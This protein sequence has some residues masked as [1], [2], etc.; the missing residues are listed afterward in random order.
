M[1]AEMRS[2]LIFAAVGAMFVLVTLARMAAA[3]TDAAWLAIRRQAVV[4]IVLGGV[5]FVTIAGR[6]QP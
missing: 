6:G 3:R 4:V 1:I 5:V 2:V